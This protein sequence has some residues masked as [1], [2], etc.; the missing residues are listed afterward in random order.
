MLCLFRDSKFRNKGHKKQGWFSWSDNN[1]SSWLLVS[2]EWLLVANPSLG[3]QIPPGPFLFAQAWPCL[4]SRHLI[5]MHWDIDA[6]ALMLQ[7]SWAW[8]GGGGGAMAPG[9]TRLLNKQANELSWKQANDLTGRL[10]VQ[11]SQHSAQPSSS[12]ATG[13]PHIPWQF[14]KTLLEWVYVSADLADTLYIYCDERTLSLN[15]QTADSW[16]RNSKV[17]IPTCDPFL[18]QRW[19]LWPSLLGEWRKREVN[20]GWF[21]W[22]QQTGK[23]MPVWIG[24]P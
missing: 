23:K 11:S 1:Q 24:S 3:R 13:H 21:V 17:E 4:L 22:F 18:S 14:P 16:E 20:R 6:C 2:S 9:W 10:T 8:K 19:E 7:A 15:P 5:A 12:S